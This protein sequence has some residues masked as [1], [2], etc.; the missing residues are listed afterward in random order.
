MTKK[1]IELGP[2]EVIDKNIG[3]RVGE[4]PVAEIVS[5]KS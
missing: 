1:I 5:D 2:A 4:L 3:H